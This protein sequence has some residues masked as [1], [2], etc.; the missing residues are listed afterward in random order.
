MILEDVQ[1]RPDVR[2]VA[3]DEVGVSG[4]RYPIVACD[5]DG[6]KQE[7]VGEVS[8]AVAL[9]AEVKGTHLS[10]FVEVLH[11]HAAEISVTTAPVIAD[12]LRVRLAAPRAQL[13]VRA[14][15]F[16][17]RRAPVSGAHA[18]MGYEVDWFATADSATARVEFGARVPVTSVCPCSKAI[19]DYGAHN[20]R[21]HITVRIR[22]HERTVHSGGMPWIEDLIDLAERSASAPVFPLLKRSDER[23][24]TMLAYDNPVFVEDMAR[25]VAQQLREDAA[26]EAFG[27]HVAND[28]SIHDHAAFAGIEWPCPG[29]L[30][31]TRWA[32]G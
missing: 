8:M 12:A 32:S 21:G 4:L 24:V 23:H 14:T 28:E 6:V 2:G 7:T 22:P 15:Y 18:L 13:R 25:N 20:Q 1:G 27:V 9:G 3:L 30:A 31:D 29:S 11:E 26:L 10:R 17:E 19:S 5:R 16:R